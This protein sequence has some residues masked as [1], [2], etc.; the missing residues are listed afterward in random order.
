MFVIFREP[1]RRVQPAESPLHDPS[2]RQYLGAVKVI[3]AFD[4]FQ[5]PA[6]EI[7]DPVDK[8]SLITS[9]SPDQ[10]KAGK[11]F[12]QTD[13]DRSGSYPILNAPG[14][15]NQCKDHP[16]SIDGNVPFA[17]LDFLPVS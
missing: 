11:A 10:L 13:E 12:K 1:S 3:T 15:H 16:K 7:L 17:S 4:D 8:L 5:I 9:V 14:M 2:L 6:A